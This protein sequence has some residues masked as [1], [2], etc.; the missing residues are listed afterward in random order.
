M[1]FRNLIR[2][3]INKLGDI[4]CFKILSKDGHG[5]KI[6][7]NGNYVIIKYAETL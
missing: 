7:Y 5:K 2:T 6:S 4:V 1:L 3:D